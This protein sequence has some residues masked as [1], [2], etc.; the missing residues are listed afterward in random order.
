MRRSRNTRS[1]SRK[2]RGGRK[3]AS[4]RRRKYRAMFKMSQNSSLENVNPINTFNVSGTIS[5]LFRDHPLTWV[6]ITQRADR[7]PARFV[8][9]CTCND[10]VNLTAS[11]P[12]CLFEGMAGRYRP[13][14]TTPKWSPPPSPDLLLDQTS[15]GPTPRT[16]F[17]WTYPNGSFVRLLFI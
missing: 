6:T 7:D 5:L 12:G 14:T 1:S 11:L 9:E 10:N 13:V 3:E 8:Y 17:L 2:K 4:F 15:V 16:D